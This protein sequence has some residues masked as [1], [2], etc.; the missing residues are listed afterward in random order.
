MS[1][2]YI[3]VG[4]ATPNNQGAISPSL[5]NVAQVSPTSN[6]VGLKF[7]DGK[8]LSAGRKL[9][10]QPFYSWLRTS[11][12]STSTS[13]VYD[14]GDLF[15]TP[16][17]GVQIYNTTY[18]QRNASE[19]AYSPKEGGW[20]MSFTLKSSALNGKK[21]LCEAVPMA[22]YVGGSDYMKCQ[23][24]SGSTYH[25]SSYT[26]IGNVGE[27]SPDYTQALFGVVEVGASDVTV[28]IKVL[29]KVGT[30]NVLS[31]ATGHGG[32][33]TYLQLSVLG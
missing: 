30:I 19:S 8:W 12:F 31:G 28:G 23:W 9:H 10:R 6:A 18:V 15:I 3:S 29:D 27:Q 16:T 20:I 14:I 25:M 24:I 4:G 13:L 2:N 5:S 22:R 11:S 1:Y 32:L 26:P 17:I 21:V 33:E 7:N